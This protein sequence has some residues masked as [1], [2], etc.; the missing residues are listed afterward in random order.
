MKK[1]ECYLTAAKKLNLELIKKGYENFV[2]YHKDKQIK[3]S[4]KGLIINQNSSAKS[5]S[6]TNFVLKAHGLPV[7]IQYE[8]VNKEQLFDCFIKLNSIAVIKPDT[9][10]QGIGVSIVRSKADLMVA[11]H[12]AAGIF[13]GKAIIEEHCTGN[14]LRII[15]ADNEFIAAA[16]RLPVQ[17]VGDGK[18]SIKELIAEHNKKY[19]DYN[20]VVD[21]VISA[22]LNFEQI[23]K[24]GEKVILNRLTNMS[25]GST[26]IDRSLK[27]HPDIVE[28]A[29]RA[30]K[31]MGMR[32]A[33]IDFL[34]NNYSQAPSSKNTVKIIEINSS[35]G[36]SPV[37]E[38]I[39]ARKDKN[40]AYDILKVLFS[41]NS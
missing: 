27:V 16:E 30:N 32:L 5:K 15:I 28:L 41:I 7:P 33:G 2:I 37:N 29:K 13:S 20:I 17:V 10:T 22:Y 3:L 40:I 34:V 38:A 4:S 25:Q 8:I 26:S 35:P 36:L 11:Y 24:I 14:D 9:G 21:S 1:F 12:K 6:K 39:N 18:L 31:A 23:P 19:L